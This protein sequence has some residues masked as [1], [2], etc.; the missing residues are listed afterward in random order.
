MTRTG[1]SAQR[2]AEDPGSAA[3]AAYAGPQEDPLLPHG[4]EDAPFYT[5]GQTA[6][7]IGVQPATLRRLDDEDFVS[8][9]RSDGGQRRY[10][11]REIAQLREI[12]D[13]TREGVT[14]PGVRRVLALRRRV[15]ELEDRLGTAEAGQADVAAG[16]GPQG[17]ESRGDG[18]QGGGEE[19]DA[20]DE[21]TQ[22][23][24]PRP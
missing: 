24:Q 11:R 22:G 17:D 16:E 23:D 12:V 5:I 7:L 1:R 13:L 15:E 8:P 6:E 14:L 3:S 2:R 10:S 4:G 9:D 20:G 19:K 21:G 18:P